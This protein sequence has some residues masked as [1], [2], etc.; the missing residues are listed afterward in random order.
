MRRMASIVPSMW[1]ATARTSK[2]VHGVDAPM[3]SS[4]TPLTTGWSV[5]T[6]LCRCSRVD[7]VAFREVATVVTLPSPRHQHRLCL[8]RT[9][10]R[11]SLGV[12]QLGLGHDRRAAPCGPADRSR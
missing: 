1:F 10:N 2:S 8:R 7:I 5:V 3:S 6:T 12:G 11:A 9:G 4:E